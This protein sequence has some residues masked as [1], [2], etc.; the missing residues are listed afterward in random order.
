MGDS[1]VDCE[2]VVSLG[3]GEVKH[4]RIVGWMSVCRN[5]KFCQV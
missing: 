2:S 1:V 4:I 5:G 3:I